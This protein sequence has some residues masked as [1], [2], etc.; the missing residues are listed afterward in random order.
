MSLR[1]QLLLLQLLIVL[2]T[3]GV[4]GFVAMRMLESQIR[5]SYEQRMIGVARSVATLPVILDAYDDPD[6]STT[7]QPIA[8]LI[9]QASGVTYVVLTDAEGIRYSHPNPDRIGEVVSTDPSVPLSGRTFVGTETGT[10]GTSWRVKVPVRDADG[11]IIGAASVGTL[12][13]TLRADLLDDLPVLVAWLIGAALVGTLGAIYVSRL[14]WRRIYRMEPEQIASLRETRDAMLHGLGEGVVAVDDEER[15]DLMNEEAQRLLSLGSDVVGRQAADVLGADLLAVLRNRDDAR[16]QLVLA[17]EQ[18][19]YARV[20][21]AKV[22]G[23]HVGD[24]L[25]LR[26]RTEVH[27]LVRDLDGARDLTQALRAQAHEFANRMH[28]VSG[29]IELDRATDALAFIAR[30]GTRAALGGDPLARGLRD[31]DVAA[32]LLAKITTAAE[33]DVRIEIE[34]DSEIDGD[35][36]TDAVTILGNLLD[37]AVNAAGPGGHVRVRLRRAGPATLIAVSDDGPGVDA[38]SRDRIFDP[39]FSGTAPGRPSRGIGLSLVQQV[40]RRRGGTVVVADGPDGGAL[41]EVTLP[42][43][44]LAQSVSEIEATAT[45]VRHDG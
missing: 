17:G 9:R 29:L 33:R 21:E 39:G 38:A 27:A 3:I 37:N 8:D 15:I 35:G 30:S 40:V 14:V 26:D 22:D 7:I 28:V 43:A 10:L 25:I 41:F 4:V 12:E 32:L 13:S 23:R 45:Q 6:P 1:L 19:L 36:T 2:L 20:N 31:P 5:D 18:I 34:P 24:V 44:R 16:Q 11:E 42:P